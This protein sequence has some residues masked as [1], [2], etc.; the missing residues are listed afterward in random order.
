MARTVFDKD[1]C[2]GCGL[3]LVVC[4]KKIIQMS[5]E[6][7]RQ[8]YHPAYVDEADMDKCIGCAFCYEMCPDTVIEVYK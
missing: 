6:I 1:R 2:K 5:G 7:N 3:C 4:P 8:G